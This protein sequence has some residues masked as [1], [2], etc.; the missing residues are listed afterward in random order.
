M[1]RRTREGSESGVGDGG[2]PGMREVAFGRPDL[3]LLT[4]P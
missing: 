2:E 4:F 3:D 1:D